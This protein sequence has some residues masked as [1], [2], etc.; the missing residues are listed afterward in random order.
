MMIDALLALMIVLLII[1]MVNN[2]VL[3]YYRFNRLLKEE[4]YRL[5]EEP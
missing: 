5:D 3:T 1:L 2:L 4:S